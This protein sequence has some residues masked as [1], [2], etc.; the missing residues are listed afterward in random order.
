VAEST[1]QRKRNFQTSGQPVGVLYLSMSD[2]CCIVV[3]EPLSEESLKWLRVRADV[4]QC[5]AGDAGFAEA[6]QSAQG[7]IVRTYTQV[8]QAMLSAA[9]RLR[10]VGRAGTGIDNIDVAACGRMGIAVVNTPAA[11][12][13]AVV[14]YVTSILTSTLRPRPKAI[15]S[16]LSTEAWSQVR[17]EVVMNRQMSECTFGILG[18][19]QI[20]RRIA[21]V[22]QAIGFTVQFCDVVDIPKN[23]RHRAAKVDLDTLLHTSDVLSLHI[24]GRP[25]NRNF[26][27]PAL[28]NLLRQD[29][30]LLNTSRGF[31]MRSTDLARAMTTRPQAQAILDVHEVEPVPADDPLLTLPNVTLLPHAASRT[32]AAQNAMSWVVQDV[33]EL[34]KKKTKA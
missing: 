7:L 4:V 31:I 22:A 19:G 10:V 27:T 25:E 1:H 16:E 14:E 23:Q 20:G 3:T 33:L 11:N 18:F 30:L 28:L 29:V 13:Q 32:K 12:R 8:D 17:Q 21:E 9:P 6:L 34:I 5:A 24:D 26:L 2:R 15:T